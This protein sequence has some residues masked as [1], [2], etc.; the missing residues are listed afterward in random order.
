MQDGE[1]WVRDEKKEGASESSGGSW[2]C[3]AAERPK[4]AKADFQK[5]ANRQDSPDRPNPL[6]VRMRRSRLAVNLGK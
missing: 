2:H 6:T 4:E 1:V 3:A 5:S